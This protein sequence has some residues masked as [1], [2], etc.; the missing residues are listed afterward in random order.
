VSYIRLTVRMILFSGF[1]LFACFSLLVLCAADRVLPQPVARTRVARR[2][3]AGLRRALGIRLDVEGQPL[4]DGWLLVSNHI[5]WLDIV[6]LGS[7]TPLNFLSKSEVSRW[8]AIGW[9]A[10]GIGTLFIE[11]R[12]GRAGEVREQIADRLKQDRQVLVFAEGTT[13]DGTTVR[14][15]HRPLLAAARQ[16]NRPAQGVSISYWRDGER[17]PIVPYINDD[18]FPSHLLRL[19]RAPAT[20]VRVTFHFPVPAGYQQTSRALARQLHGQVLAGIQSG[21]SPRQAEPLSYKTT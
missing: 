1:L 19:L 13:T 3:L 15:F 18:H 16:V 17:D 7:L 20:R 4:E 21:S 5:S 9:L 10:R 12:S 14:P 11:R 8:P 2:Y 6:I